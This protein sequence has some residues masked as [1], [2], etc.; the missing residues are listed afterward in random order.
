M[1][2]GINH[3][4]IGC[5]RI[6]QNHYNAAIENKMNVVACC[7]L[8]LELAREFSKKNNIPFYTK[9]YY[10][11]LNNNE[12]DSV[13]ICTDH[14]SHVE[15]AKDFLNK[16]NIIIE[17]PL[18]SNFELAQNFYNDCKTNNKVITVISQHRFDM[19]VNLVKEMVLDGA[20][21]DITL[22]NAQLVCQ[23]SDEYYSKSYWRG[24]K[25]L[26]G[27]STIINQS[28]HIVD[29]IN[30]LFGLPLN[31]KSYKK[32][33]RFTDINDTE[34]TCV[35]I[36]N[37]ETFL[38]TI[39]STNTSTKEWETTIEIIGTKGNVKFNIDFPEE[40][41][42]LNVDE[43]YLKKY[44]VKL[45]RIDENY[46]KNINSMVNYYG[47]SHLFQFKNFK[48]SVLN[49]SKIKVGVKQALET[50]KFIKMIY[51]N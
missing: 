1:K 7:D 23:R 32:N 40:I 45:K 13:S 43:M 21:G 3:A 11:I 48:E 36:A 20:F 12:I 27:G 26:E 35:S 18:S 24:K 2:K 33:L 19:V 28:F 8:N 50:Q 10:D 34:D 42:E 37:Y 16:K 29:T 44:A 17:K 46:K 30:Y 41:L 22:V 5:G 25:D 9:D 39:S 4:I 49:E 31:V 15:I 47:L 6:A 51:D 14:K 38:C